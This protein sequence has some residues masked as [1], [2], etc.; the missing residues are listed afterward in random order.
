MLLLYQYN[1]QPFLQNSLGGRVR[2]LI[3]GSAP[4][5]DDVMVFLRCALG[6]Q[7]S[8]QHS[9]LVGLRVVSYFVKRQESGQNI[10]TRAR[11]RETLRTREANKQI[12]P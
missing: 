2:F 11:E 5:R 1:F 4:L 7:V 6:C 8:Q 9:F 3:S 10:F 12:T